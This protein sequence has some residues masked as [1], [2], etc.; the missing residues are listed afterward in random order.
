MK[1]VALPVMAFILGI[2]LTHV[3]WMRHLSD[4]YE[5]LSM[6]VD[7]VYAVQRTII[8]GVPIYDDFMKPGFES[9]LRTYLFPRHIEAARSLGVGPV[10]DMDEC[11]KLVEKGALVSI[12]GEDLPYYFYGVKKEHRYLTPGAARGLDIIA[13]TFR[14]VQKEHG[15]NA[16]IK[17]ALSSALRPASYQGQ[18]RGTNMNAVAESTHSYGVSV[19]LFFD[20][21]YVVL[22]ETEDEGVLESIASRIR[23]RLGYLAGDA[24][25]RQG[26]TLLAMTVHRLQK[27][28]VI[29][30]TLE[31]NQRCFHI[32]VVKP[33]NP[34]K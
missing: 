21:F 7:K 34:V 14:E 31:R 32:T 17:F 27:E 2:V 1:K 23:S 3:C 25:R 20:D 10:G 4:V 30:V 13:S 22:P 33:E 19:D 9:E 29:Y 28:G 16:P 11:N 12:D 5:D 18:L 6:Y 24:L 26:K 15:I 8:E